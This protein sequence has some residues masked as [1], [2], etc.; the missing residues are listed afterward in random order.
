MPYIVLIILMLSVLIIL[1]FNMMLEA[2]ACIVKG[3][4]RIH[5]HC[6]KVEEIK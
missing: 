1:F 6:F 2:E 3:G 5:G 4:V